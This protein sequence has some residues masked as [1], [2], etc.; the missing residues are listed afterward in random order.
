MKKIK[1]KALSILLVLCITVGIMPLSA[2]AQ[3]DYTSWVIEYY[4]VTNNTI[5]TTT[6]TYIPTSDFAEKLNRY[7]TT[8]DIP[9]ST[10]NSNSQKGAITAPDGYELVYGKYS[11]EAAEINP[12]DANGVPRLGYI[13]I[14][15]QPEIISYQIE[16]ACNEG[17]T[18]VGGGTYEQ[19]SNATIKAIANPGYHF[20]RWIEDTQVVSTSSEYTF[21]VTAS[22]YLTAEFEECNWSDW[23][24]NGNN[25]HSKECSVCHIVNTENCTGGTGDC[26]HKP[27]CSIC[28]T[29]YA[30]LGDHEYGELITEIP[31]TNEEKGI[32]AHYKCK[33][34]GEL[35]DQ[36]KNP[37]TEE[38]LVISRVP[39]LEW[40]LEFWDVKNDVKIESKYKTVTISEKLARNL[41]DKDDL[42]SGEKEY[43]IPLSNITGYSDEMLPEDYELAAGYAP[44]PTRVPTINKEGITIWIQKITYSV[45]TE[46]LPSE[47]GTV[48]GDGTYEIKSNVTVNATPKEGYHFVKWITEDGNTVSSEPTYSFDILENIKLTA[49]FE[50]CFGGTASYFNRAICKKCGCEYGD[51]LI[52]MT[53]PT[54]EIRIGENQWNQFLNK[55][56][57]GLFFNETQHVKLTAWDDSY[58]VS[59]YTEDKAATIGYYISNKEMT[60]EEVKSVDNWK[61]YENSFNIE[62]DNEYIIYVKITDHAGNCTYINSDG[63]VLDSTVPVISGIENG[64]SYY[65][66][67]TFKI[68]EK[69]AITVLVDGK[70]V[71]L[72]EDN[73]YTIMADNKPH[74]ITAID[75]AGNKTEKNIAVYKYYTVNYVVDGIIINTQQVAYGKDATAP[76]IPEKEGYTQTAPAW[77]HDGKNITKDTVITAV[78]IRDVVSGDTD[79]QSPQTGDTS[80]LFFWFGLLM[81]CATVVA[82]IFIYTSY[83]RRRK[84]EK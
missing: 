43:D 47:G 8:M 25:T 20:V 14:K 13:R 44:S 33:L 23:R 36:N 83:Q 79:D 65:G 10:L 55:L 18:V 63:L 69:Y 48:S 51:L 39:K 66:D 2:Y 62:A 56:T 76:Q 9:Q 40:N 24:S 38:A 57:F 74:V 75:Q 16:V 53:V 80:K 19:G 67:T 1:S 35:F 61:E 37:V 45:T 84:T 81:I 41:A 54:G 82:G 26:M 17:G 15:V 27:I 71:E 6:G 34:C 32:K 28:Q 49:V 77:D 70:E 72:K 5:L 7:T 73:T 11:L 21:N 12:K 31:A 29:E 64:K 22:K 59:G 42:W 78:Y 52:D 46:A 60:L 30:D 3:D 4:D 50:P 68:S 58:D